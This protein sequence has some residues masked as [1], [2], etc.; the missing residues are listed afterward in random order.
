MSE[1]IQK[2]VELATAG[3]LRGELTKW[4]KADVWWFDDA[5]PDE[6]REKGHADPALN[7]FCQFASPQ[8]RGDDGFMDEAANVAISFN[9]TQ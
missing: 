9:R 5:M 7:Y 4:S 1:A 6:V 3:G 2:L 8:Y